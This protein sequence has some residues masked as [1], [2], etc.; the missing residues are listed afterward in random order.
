M[1]AST[2]R[3]ALD[4]VVS[5]IEGSATDGDELDVYGL[6]D[7]DGADDDQVDG[8][9]LLTGVREVR[10]RANVRRYQEQL[11][12]YHGPDDSDTEIDFGDDAASWKRLAGEDCDDD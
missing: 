7:P 10:G 11:A 1:T 12:A 9:F 4:L 2:I 6:G 5:A 8:S 3:D